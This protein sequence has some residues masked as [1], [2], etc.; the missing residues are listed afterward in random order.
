[1]PMT[2][3]ERERVAYAFLAELFDGHEVLL[4][5]FGADKLKQYKRRRNALGN[6]T[7]AMKIYLN[8]KIKVCD[9]IGLGKVVPYKDD[10]IRL[11]QVEWPHAVKK[12]SLRI[13]AYF[14][15]VSLVDPKTRGIDVIG[16]LV[17]IREFEML[18]G[19]RQ[20]FIE[21]DWY[22]EWLLEMAYNFPREVDFMRVE[23]MTNGGHK[24]MDRTMDADAP[25]KKGP[26]AEYVAAVW[27][28]TW[29]RKQG[30]TEPLVGACESLYT[31]TERKD[32]MYRYFA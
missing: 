12:R 6:T 28:E 17:C 14:A 25:W 5:I 9:L 31:I 26:F 16:R 3:S 32:L 11:M 13:A 18:L 24:L 4:P 20:A 23:T 8:N 21:I 27:H 29:A 7:V 22:N 19:V 10:P 2:T 15:G 1:M 30:I